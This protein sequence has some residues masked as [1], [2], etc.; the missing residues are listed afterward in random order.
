MPP[1]APIPRKN[2]VPSMLAAGGAAVVG[3]A[4]GVAVPRAP[5]PAGPAS[6]APGV[7]AAHGEPPPQAVAP[8]STKSP[9][10]AAATRERRVMA[11]KLGLSGA[12]GYSASRS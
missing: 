8:T 10:T 6:L 7:G 11:A 1:A 5:V 2:S 9:A 12:V 4:L 3:P